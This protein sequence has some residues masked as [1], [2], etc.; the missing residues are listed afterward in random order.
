MTSVSPSPLHTRS[1][2]TMPR[3][4]VARV[5]V[6]PF[7]ELFGASEPDSVCR[8]GCDVEGLSP[9]EAA[10]V[11]SVCVESVVGQRARNPHVRE[12]G[13]TE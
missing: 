1:Y 2:F 8:M 13:G 10:K 12:S 5:C 4:R 3:I 6:V 9:E 7:K 11:F